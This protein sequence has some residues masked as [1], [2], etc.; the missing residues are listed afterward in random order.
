MKTSFFKPFMLIALLISPTLSL[1]A[2]VAAADTLASAHSST[3]SQ[4]ALLIYTLLKLA[5]KSA[6]I[7][8]DTYYDL[9]RATEQGALHYGISAAVTDSLTDNTPQTNLGGATIDGIGFITTS[10]VVRTA[11]EWFFATKAGASLDAQLN[12]AFPKGSEEL[13]KETIIGFVSAALY[14]QLKKFAPILLPAS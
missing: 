7:N 12:K 5:K 13:R 11:Y 8:D 4:A 10:W 3:K 6:T 1:P 14:A 2:E 9:L